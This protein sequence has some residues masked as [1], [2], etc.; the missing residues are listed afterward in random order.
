MISAQVELTSETDSFPSL[1]NAI[2]ERCRR[3]DIPLLGLDEFEELSSRSPSEFSNDFFLGLRALAQLGMP[4][5]TSSRRSLGELMHVTG[6]RPLSLIYFPLFALGLSLLMTL[7][8]LL[9]CLAPGYPHFLQKH[10][11]P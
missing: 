3:G 2:E 9:M 4:I 8:V 1:A 5:V 6:P 10:D 11:P 7:P